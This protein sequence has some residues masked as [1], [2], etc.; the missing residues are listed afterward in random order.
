MQRFLL[1]LPDSCIFLLYYYIR[2]HTGMRFSIFIITFAH[3]LINNCA[4][5]LLWL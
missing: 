2:G 1:A 3:F 4:F 5:Y